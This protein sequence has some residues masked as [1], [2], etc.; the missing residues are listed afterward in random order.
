MVPCDAVGPADAL[1][2]QDEVDPVIPDA[3][4]P[5]IPCKDALEIPAPVTPVP[6]IPGDADP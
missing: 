1:V 4:A 2:I 5:M 6:V 3:V